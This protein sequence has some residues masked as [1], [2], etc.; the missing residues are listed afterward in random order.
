[1]VPWSLSTPLTWAERSA[2]SSPR[3]SRVKSSDSGSGPRR[4]TPGTSAT[5]RTRY[6]ARLFRVPASV[7]S[8]PEPSESRRR[9]ATGD[10]PG[11]RTVR[12]SSSLKRNQPAR[13][14]C[15]TRC[16]PS[17][18]TS[19]NLPWRCTPSTGAPSMVCGGGST[20]L[21]TEKEASSSRST[22]SPARRSPR[23]S[24]SPWT[25]GSS[26][27]LALPSTS[28]ECLAHLLEHRVPVRGPADRQLDADVLLVV[29]RRD[30]REVAEQLLGRR[31]HPD[32][33]GPDPVGPLLGELAV[34][35]GIVLPVVADEHPP[36]L[37]QLPGET[38][39]ARPLV[40]PTGAEPAGVGRAPVGHEHRAERVAGAAEEA[41]QRR[42][43]VPRARRD[44]DD[45]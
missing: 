45:R 26:G 38:V 2:S 13:A 20:V 8:K 23:K 41:G 33:D 27:I 28:S 3:T 6:T 10:L 34:E 31:E 9:M 19:M 24:T 36:H 16:V 15:T 1:M 29:V 7:R 25:S 44:V 35:T 21:R 12:G 39:Q 14:R 43:G 22:A 4:A 30:R 11:R 18:S 17:Q 5:S 32:P 42:H 37:G 40:V